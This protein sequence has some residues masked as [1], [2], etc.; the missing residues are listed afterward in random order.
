MVVVF[1]GGGLAVWQQQDKAAEEQVVQGGA[2]EIKVPKGMKERIILADGTKVWL[3]S[4]SCLTLSPGFGQ[5]DRE[6]QLEGEGMFEVAKDKHKPFIIRSGDIRVRV[7][8]TVFNFKSYPEERFA[9]VTLVRGSLDVSS[10]T[11]CVPH[12]VTLKP[13]EQVVLD[14][15][16]DVMEKK[17]VETA[18]DVAWT[19][20][21]Q[22]DEGI[23][24]DTA[25]TEMTEH[26]GGAEALFF[27]EMSMEQIVQELERV[28]HVNIVVKKPGILQEKYYGD[29]RNRKDIFAILDVM[30]RGEQVSYQIKG[31]TVFIG[32]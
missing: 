10:V 13:C 19:C 23:S 14:R 29:F 12:T 25:E 21:G 15:N 18:P 7:T 30:L 24:E 1:L 27:D 20:V 2:R 9:K 26:A 5:A 22:R 11:G 17:V 6:L 32:E 31:D 8:G 4:G 16:R 3:N 28:F